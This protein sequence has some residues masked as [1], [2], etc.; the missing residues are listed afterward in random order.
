MP[1]RHNIIRQAQSQTRPLPSRLSSKKRLEDLVFDGNEFC[2]FIHQSPLISI[3]LSVVHVLIQS[4]I[5]P[6]KVN[7]ASILKQIF[8]GFRSRVCLDF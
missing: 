1:L 8:V 6:Q 3:Q 7:K 4:L 5:L 2:V